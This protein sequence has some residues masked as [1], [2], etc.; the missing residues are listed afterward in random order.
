MKRIG[1][2][3]SYEGSN[4]ASTARNSCLLLGSSVEILRHA[5]SVVSAISI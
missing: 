4:M 2:A 3:P 1:I 5:V